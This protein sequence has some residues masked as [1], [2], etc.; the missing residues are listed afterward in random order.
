MPS[1]LAQTIAAIGPL[2]SDALVAAAARQAQL[3]KPAGPMGRLEGLGERLEHPDDA[4]LARGRRAER[5]QTPRGAGWH[6]TRARTRTAW[7]CPT[8]P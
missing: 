7:A 5:A 6:S 4:G 1:L 3:T 8:G 2:D